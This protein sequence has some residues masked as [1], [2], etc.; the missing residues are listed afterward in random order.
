ME[1]DGL[2]ARCSLPTCRRLDYLPY[3]CSGCKK[4]FCDEHRVLSA[5]SCA[6]AASRIIPT[7]PL[8]G[9]A[10]PAAAGMTADTAVSRHIDAGCPKRLRSN[11]PCSLPSC[12]VRDPAATPCVACRRIFC[13]AHCVEINHNCS[14][15]RSTPQ[16]IFGGGLSNSNVVPKNVPTKKTER[17]S[18]S[19]K[20]SGRQS[21][22]NTSSTS[23]GDKN[24]DV[25]NRVVLAVHFPPEANLNPR[26]MHFSDKNSAGK[27]IDVI[28]KFV[29]QLPSPPDGTRY[30]LYALKH[31]LTRVNLLPYI[32]PL[33][34]L[35]GI[36]QAGDSLVIQI[37]DAG[38]DPSV[39]ETF[40]PKQ[41]PQFMASPLGRKIPKIPSTKTRKCL[42]A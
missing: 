37:G 26:Y 23:I 27:I 16:G 28:R 2:G 36:I 31:D 35:G 7:C 4:E 9:A 39:L 15:A 13:V 41:A 1:V 3:R 22:I 30:S 33:R 11:P 8:C 20:K 21:F 24:V 42:V 29:P 32:T 18:A 10:V 14:A 17:H 12:K 34:E 19:A 40:Q 25:D 38:I 6:A 5:H